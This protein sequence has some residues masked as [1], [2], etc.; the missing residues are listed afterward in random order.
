[1]IVQGITYAS[2]DN[3]GFTEP[4][5]SGGLPLGWY[6]R[7]VLSGSGDR[8]LCPHCLKA[9][10]AAAESALQA[11]KTAI[12]EPRPGPAGP[13]VGGNVLGGIL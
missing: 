11:R 13:L 3:C 2:C 6:S 7:W 5:P 4:A 8:D 10:Q 12:T 9:V 1:M